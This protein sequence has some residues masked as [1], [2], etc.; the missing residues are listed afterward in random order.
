MSLRG[1][2]WPVGVFVGA[3]VFAFGAYTGTTAG[4]RLRVSFSGPAPAT[5][6]LRL[7][8]GREL[9]MTIEPGELSVQLPP[10]LVDGMAT[11][12][13]D[14]HTLDLL[15]H[16]VVV[17][18]PRPERLP[19]PGPRRAARTVVRDHSRVRLVSTTLIVRVRVRDR[20]PLLSSRTRL[21]RSSAPEPRRLLERAT[22]HLI[23]VDRVHG[24]RPGS[25]VIGLSGVSRVRR[26]DG[27]QAEEALLL[28]L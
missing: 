16:G 23:T 11:I 19:G 28:M 12:T 9:V 21:L 18:A 22:W 14:G 5:A 7:A 26:R 27:R 1:T 4:D 6:V 17:V 3:P 25:S 20:Q 8:D 10:D 13:A 24:A 15:L 2:T